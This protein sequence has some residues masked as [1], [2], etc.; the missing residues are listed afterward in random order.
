MWPTTEEATRYPW[1]K[2]LGGPGSCGE[3]DNFSPPPGI[4]PL[5][6]S[7]QTELSLLIHEYEVSEI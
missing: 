4:L 2:L 7:P 3:D 5:P 6:S 1:D